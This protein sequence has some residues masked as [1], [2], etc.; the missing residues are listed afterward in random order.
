MTI[1]NLIMAFCMIECH[2]HQTEHNT[3]NCAI[4]DIIRTLSTNLLYIIR[5]RRLYNSLGPFLTGCTSC[6]TC[7]VHGEVY[8][9]QIQYYV[10]K[11]VNDLQPC[12]WFTP[13]SF[14]NKSDRHDTTEMLLKVA[15]STTTPPFSTSWSRNCFKQWE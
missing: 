11:Y 2:N 14:T 15:L 9:I 5:V 3:F 12:L 1:F 13:V 8:S 6:W 4:N 7:P 10:I